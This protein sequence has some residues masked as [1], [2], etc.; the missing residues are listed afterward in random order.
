VLAKDLSDGQ[1]IKQPFIVHSVEKSETKT[2]S[3]YIKVEL[4]DRSGRVSGRIWDNVDK[5][6]SEA[7][8]G[9]IVI[10]SG[11]FSNHARFGKQVAVKDLRQANE[12]EYNMEDI[13][14]GPAVPFDQLE[15]QFRTLI[16]SIQD[17]DISA[18][19]E[20]LFN[21]DTECW[22]QF[23][24]APAAKHFHQAYD[25]GLLEHTV[26][27][28]QTVSAAAEVFP[29]VDHDIALCGALIHDIGKIDAYGGKEEGFDLT[30]LGRLQGEIPLGYYR[31]RRTVEELKDFSPETAMQILHIVLSHHGQLEHGSPVLPST[32]E[33]ALV[34]S[35]DN[36]GGKLGSFDRLEKGLDKGQLWA[37]FDRAI[38]TNAYFNRINTRK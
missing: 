8:I 29:D 2:G 11:R 6:A 20:A 35:I 4:G 7:K 36:L 23:S 27:V 31:V 21:P 38:G 34:H 16:S 17:E 24:I 5:L 25:H 18:L 19:L 33:A 30:P 26:T 10:V 14:E 1:E 28:A 32:R 15:K 9:E 12:D 13:T 3:P 22:K 37:G